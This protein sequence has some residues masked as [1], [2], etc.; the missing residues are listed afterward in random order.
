MIPGLG[1]EVMEVMARKLKKLR[2]LEATFVA[3]DLS[4]ALALRSRVEEE[5][6]MESETSE[7]AEQAQ[8]RFK[9]LTHLTLNSC[10][11]NY[12]YRS[13]SEPSNLSR[14]TKYI[15]FRL[16]LSDPSSSSALSSPKLADGSNSNSLSTSTRTTVTISDVFDVTGMEPDTR[17]IYG[18]KYCDESRYPINFEHFKERYGKFDRMLGNMLDREMGR[19]GDGLDGDGSV[20]DE[21]HESESED[22]D[23][24]EDEDE[25]EYPCLYGNEASNGYDLIPSNSDSSSSSGCYAGRNY[26]GAKREF[27]A[28]LLPFR[29]EGL[30][31]CLCEG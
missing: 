31:L 21:D 23:E 20:G 3:S 28:L 12:D 27:F 7:S 18:R 22:G 24:D 8:A 26:L 16:P 11:I 30:I 13:F 25:D 6:K 14:L 10:F 9:S 17:H 1:V 5:G 19:G 15:S 4:D 2:V 29:R